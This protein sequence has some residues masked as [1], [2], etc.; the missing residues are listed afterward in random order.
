MSNADE[1]PDKRFLFLSNDRLA[2]ILAGDIL[3]PANFRPLPENGRY[4][5]Y[6]SA[7]IRAIMAAATNL[8]LERNVND[9]KAISQAYLQLHKQQ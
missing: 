7:S 5:S 4:G 1:V 9:A 3:S 6:R 2:S 8:V